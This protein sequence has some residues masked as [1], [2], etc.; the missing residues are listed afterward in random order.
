MGI[1][2]FA[3]DSDNWLSEQAEEAD[4]DL[5]IESSLID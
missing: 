5:F 3:E 4:E 1:L 2:E